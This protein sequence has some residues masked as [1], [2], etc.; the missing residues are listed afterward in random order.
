[1]CV[2]VQDFVQ[3]PIALHLTSKSVFAQFFGFLLA[4]TQRT[5]A[6]AIMILT[7]VHH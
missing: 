3:W 2:N 6:T 4:L 5:L 1:M 7:V